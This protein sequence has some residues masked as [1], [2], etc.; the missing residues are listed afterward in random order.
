MSLQQQIR[1]D[2]HASMKDRD[3][4]RTSAL[5][6]VVAAI[7]NRAVEQGLGPQGE[8]DDEE[9]RRLLATQVKQREEAAEAYRDGGREDRAA[10]EEAEAAI[11]AE[12]LP[13]QLGDDELGELI[14]GAIEELGASG[15]QDMGRVMGRVMDEVGTRADG[16]HVADLVRARLQGAG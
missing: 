9:V 14:D 11:F 6:M 13:E 10:E 12:Y 15:M 8:L 7:N 16:G 1:D 5:R 2:L 3:T 4:R